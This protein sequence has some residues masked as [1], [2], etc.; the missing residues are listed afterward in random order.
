MSRTIAD[1]KAAAEAS[2]PA[3]TFL[4]R[5]VSKAEIDV[6]AERRRHVEGEGWTPEHDDQHAAGELTEA[7]MS[8]C[9]PAAVALK[10]IA[11]GMATV[12]IEGRQATARCPKSWPWSPSWWKP[13]G[14]TRRILVKAAAL[15]LAEIERIDRKAEREAS[16]GG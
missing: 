3:F 16:H 6:L 9:I 10:L 13:A 5:V 12:D 7:A 8:Y 15:L 2:V 11:A 14:G 4:G 1:M